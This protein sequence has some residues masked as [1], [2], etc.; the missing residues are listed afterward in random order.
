LSDGSITSF[1]AE[2]FS[3]S[4]WQA[5]QLVNHGHIEV[6]GRKVDIPSFPSKSAMLPS[7]I[8]ASKNVHVRRRVAVTAVGRGRPTWIM[9]GEDLS[10]T[11]SGLPTSGYRCK[12]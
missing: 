4:R 11:V 1:I 6:N 5:R 9:G 8:K 10:I 12:Y 2:V 7:K 3:T